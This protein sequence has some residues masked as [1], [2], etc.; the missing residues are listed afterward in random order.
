MSK[1]SKCGRG[2]QKY[3][4]RKL[5][6]SVAFKNYRITSHV[7]RGLG[8]KK[9]F[10]EG[11]LLWETGVKSASKKIYLPDAGDEEGQIALLHNEASEVYRKE[12]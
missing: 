6:E 12:T 10:R 3:C 4:L 2:N 8:R 1:T 9:V 7:G 5:A 11:G